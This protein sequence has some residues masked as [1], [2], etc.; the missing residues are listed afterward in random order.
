MFNSPRINIEPTN[1]HKNNDKHKHKSKKHKK[2]KKHKNDN[3]VSWTS[4]K[5]LTSDMPEQNH[6]ELENLCVINE[7]TMERE[8]LNGDPIIIDNE[9][10]IGVLQPMFRTTDADVSADSTESVK[11]TESNERA[12]NHFRP[13]KRRFEI[14]MQIKLKQ[15]PDGQLFFGA[16]LDEMLDIGLVQRT[17]LGA[18]MSFIQKKNNGLLYNL[19]GEKETE[20]RE[21]EKPHIS[22]WFETSADRFVVTKPGEE[23][24]QLGTD[25]YEDP[26]EWERRKKG[27]LKIIY[28]TEDTYTVAVWSA[29]IDFTQWKILNIPAISSFTLSSSIGSQVF[30]IH[31]YLADPAL[32]RHRQKDIKRI[33]SYEFG[34][35][36]ESE[37]GPSASIYLEKLKLNRMYELDQAASVEAIESK[38]TI[39]EAE[40]TIIG[41]LFSYLA[42]YKWESTVIIARGWLT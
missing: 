23:P 35:T 15:V 16:E 19:S 38:R 13:K 32:E 40:E 37:V 26:D 7:A 9:L 28:N 27:D 12:S 39:E 6:I 11:G 17:F 2:H 14:Q 29:Y 18:I 1:N 4:Q 10:M 21:Y 33:L 25:I 8:I 3:M 41:G 30:R 22:L 34:H 20:D 42:S 36:V 31:W 5:A 24:P